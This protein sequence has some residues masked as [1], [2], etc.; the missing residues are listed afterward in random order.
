MAFEPAAGRD[1]TPRKQCVC[2][3]VPPT[4]NQIH[5]EDYEAGKIIC[6]AQSRCESIQPSYVGNFVQMSFSFFLVCLF[7]FAREAVGHKPRDSKFVCPA[8]FSQ[9]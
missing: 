8:C 9:P 3:C 4:L 7:C 5:T 6:Q 2:V 1:V